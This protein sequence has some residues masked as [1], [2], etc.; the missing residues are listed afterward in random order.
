MKVSGILTA[1]LCIETVLA[2]PFV[3]LGPSHG[4]ALVARVDRG[5][6]HGS[7]HKNTSKSGKAKEE[8]GYHDSERHPD[9]PAKDRERVNKALAEAPSVKG[10]KIPIREEGDRPRRGE[11]AMYNDHDKDGAP[12]TTHVMGDKAGK[13]LK[14]QM[15]REKFYPN[16]RYAERKLASDEDYA[17]M[18]T[19][20]LGNVIA[21]KDTVGD[22]PPP[23]GTRE[24]KTFA[25]LKRIPT[26]HKDVGVQGT[27]VGW[28]TRQEASTADGQAGRKL[29]QIGQ[30]H[31]DKD[32]REYRTQAN[33]SK[34]VEED[35]DPEE[36][37]W[38]KAPNGRDIGENIPEREMYPTAKSMYLARRRSDGSDAARSDSPKS[39]RS[40]SSNHRRRSPELTIRAKDKTDRRDRRDRKR[41]AVDQ[42][43]QVQT[44]AES[45]HP[46]TMAA[47]DF[48]Q[49]YQDYLQAFSMLRTN[50]TNLLMPIVEDMVEGSDSDL[51]WGMAW[52]ILSLAEPNIQVTRSLF[53]GGLHACDWYED[54]VRN[55]TNEE[56]MKMLLAVDA[57][58][59]DIY[60]AA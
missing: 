40:K 33:P 47:G 44:N 38:L 5:S 43:A 56:S 39:D 18:R 37:L 9:A 8:I 10:V 7:P 26:N 51:I 29:K 6:R 14:L 2:F 60:Q 22:G 20:T 4:K 25:R 54:S 12:R 45:S 59:I 52:E 11:M 55:T 57:V 48:R 30:Q 1:A 32:S 53:H 58:L 41:D 31:S 46:D 35:Y 16:E 17:N 3:G 23:K 13:H 50:A 21:A 34:E 27:S 24:E 49:Q 28:G 36:N 19:T 15:G 42:A